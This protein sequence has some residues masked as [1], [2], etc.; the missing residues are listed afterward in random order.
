MIKITVPRRVFCGGSW[1]S[2]TN[3][4]EIGRSL[5]NHTGGR[6][7]GLGFRVLRRIQKRRKLND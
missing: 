6:Y 3:Y 4:C 1:G 7:N 2:D 5:N